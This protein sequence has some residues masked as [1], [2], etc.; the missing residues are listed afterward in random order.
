MQAGTPGMRRAFAS[1]IAEGGTLH[2]VMQPPKPLPFSQ[3]AGIDAAGMS[4]AQMLKAL[5]LKVEH[6][7]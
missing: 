6:S 1:F 2:Y 4:P 5:G 3:L 7:K